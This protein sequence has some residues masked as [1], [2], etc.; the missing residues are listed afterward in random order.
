MFTLLAAMDHTGHVPAQR[1]VADKSSEIP[2][3]R[4]LLDHGRTVSRGREH[5]RR[6]GK[7]LLARR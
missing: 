7:V 6:S 1:Q 5:P 2:A 3:F 4:P